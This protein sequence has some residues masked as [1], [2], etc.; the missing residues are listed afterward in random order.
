[1]DSLRRYARQGAGN[2]IISP[3]APVY[4]CGNFPNENLSF[5]GAKAKAGYSE[6]GTDR[7][8]FTGK[9]GFGKCCCD[10]R[11]IGNVE[12]AALCPVAA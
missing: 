10:L 7:A 12:C 1:M 11:I 5:L 9:G 3:V 6:L 8:L 4:L 2:R